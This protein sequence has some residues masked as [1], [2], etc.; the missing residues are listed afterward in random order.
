MKYIRAPLSTY[1]VS[2]VHRGPKKKIEK[3]NGSSV[4]KRAPNE[5]GL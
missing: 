1:S 4:S 3:I 2:A 5:N